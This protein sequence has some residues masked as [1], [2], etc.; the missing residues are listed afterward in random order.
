MKIHHVRIT[1]EEVFEDGSSSTTTW[2]VPV[3]PDLPEK[4]AES[5]WWAVRDIVKEEIA[6]AG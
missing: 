5:I 3:T 2:E 1:V 6:N 4:D